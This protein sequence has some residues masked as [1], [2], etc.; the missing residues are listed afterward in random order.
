MILEDISLVD[1]GK[2]TIDLGC[3]LFSSL[4]LF[5]PLA[6]FFDNREPIDAVA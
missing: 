3:V 4:G 1:V 6:F 5:S 2:N